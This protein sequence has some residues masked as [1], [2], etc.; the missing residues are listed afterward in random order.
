MLRAP[1]PAIAEPD[2]FAA[3]AGRMMKRTMYDKGPLS[4][5]G[6]PLRRRR[7]TAHGRVA[8]V[9]VGEDQPSTVG[10]LSQGQDELAGIRITALRYVS[11]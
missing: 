10:S 2:L 8:C 6:S 4:S 7:R 5:A 9:H 11:T 3:R 1:A